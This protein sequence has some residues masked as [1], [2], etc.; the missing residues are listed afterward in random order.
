MSHSFI[1]C[2]WI[3]FGILFV[4]SNVANV[5]KSVYS[6]AFFIGI[7]LYTDINWGDWYQRFFLSIRYIEYSVAIKISIGV[8]YVEEKPTIMKEYYKISY[9]ICIFHMNIQAHI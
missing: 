6:H 1:L 8:I 9:K 4:K 7:C 5:L 3:E 2:L